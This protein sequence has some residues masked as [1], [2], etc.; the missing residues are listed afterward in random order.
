LPAHIGLTRERRLR[1]TRKSPP[2]PRSH[3]GE[4]C[5]YSSSKSIL[6]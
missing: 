6:F 3:P 1:E 2:Y 4:Q 5:V